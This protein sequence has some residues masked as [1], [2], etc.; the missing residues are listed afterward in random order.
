[1][2]WKW[3]GVRIASISQRMV[4]ASKTS[5]VLVDIRNQDQTIFVV[6]AKGNDNGNS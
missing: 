3:C 5:T 4:F 1:M 2:L 6:M